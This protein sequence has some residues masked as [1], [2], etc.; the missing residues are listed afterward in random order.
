MGILRKG[1]AA[2]NE[3][4]IRRYENLTLFDG[5]HCLAI[6]ITSFFVIFS[7]FLAGKRSHESFAVSTKIQESRAPSVS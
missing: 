7:I 4:N 6:G 1:Q 2:L 5:E 3:I